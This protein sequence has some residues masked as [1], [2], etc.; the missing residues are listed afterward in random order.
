MIKTPPDL[1]GQ[2]SG[3]PGNAETAARILP[4]VDLASVEGDDTEARI[5][6]L[7]RRGADAGV[8]AVCVRPRFVSL[9]RE[10]LRGT[11][12]GLAALA[13]FPD[14]GDDIA[15]AVDETARA[16][17]D[18]ADEIDLV[19]PIE[20][21]LDGDV[22]L[23]TELVQGCKAA[24]G[25]RVLKVALETGRLEQPARITAAARAAIMAGADCLATSTGGTPGGATLE[26]AAVLLAVI[27]EADGKVGL[28]VAGGLRTT[29]DAAQYLYL[30]D[31]F[32]D[33]GWTR[34]ETLRFG[35]S[36]SLVDSLQRTLGSAGP[37][38]DGNGAGDGAPDAG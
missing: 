16:I 28:K 21:I 32:M 11:G 13:N 19:A 38:C 12:V 2:A 24:A 17:E 25:A 27:E 34:P 29:R 9:A 14:A 7:C 6:S 15:R 31:H 20:A 33:P 10:R 36:G 3:A 35:G 30:A 18:G 1:L 26:A 8:A 37:D 23:V 22:G 4:L 5:E